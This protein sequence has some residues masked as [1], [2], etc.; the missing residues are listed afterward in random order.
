MAFQTVCATQKWTEVK[1]G[2]NLEHH[3]STKYICCTSYNTKDLEL[4]TVLPDWQN[5]GS[6]QV[7]L[8]GTLSPSADVLSGVP[9]GTVLGPLSLYIYVCVCVYILY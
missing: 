1:W 9:H 6:R 3:N 4:D 2:N 7:A 5:T 8:G